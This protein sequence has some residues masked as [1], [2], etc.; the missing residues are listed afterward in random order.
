MKR[1]FVAS[2]FDFLSSRLPIEKLS[3]KHMVTEKDV[4]VH[5]MSWGYYVGGLALFFFIIQ[6]V[7]G[8]MLLFYY[9]PTVSEAHESVE[10]ITHFVTMGALVR[11]LHAWSASFMIFCVIT[12]MLTSLAMKAFA[13]PREITWIA[14]VLLLLVTFGFGFTGYLLPWNQIAVN[15]TKVGLAS[16]DQVGQYLPA[17]L[18]HLAEDV[19]VT[20][21]GAPAIGQ[22]T[23][24]RFFALHVVILPLLVLGVIGLHLLS[25]QLHGMSPG[26]EEKPVRKEKFFPFFILKDFK[27]WGIAFLVVFVLALCLPF[28]SLFPYPLLEPYN[29]LGSTPDGIKPEWYFYFVYYP[30]ELLPF[31]IIIVVMTTANLGLF[32]APWIFK[33]AS[34]KFMRWIASAIAAYLII[35]TLFGESI[36]HAIKG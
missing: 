31:W 30:M 1:S 23:L 16:I 3:F 25:V 36:Y 28:D 22:A 14:G 11:N 13:K 8:L 18:S 6:V 9:E 20:I 33:G 32:A 29:A 15:A 5:R 26:I 35:M 10:Y 19:R 7:T 27:E 2:T 24:S 17:A 4:P 34:H 21:Q 12:H